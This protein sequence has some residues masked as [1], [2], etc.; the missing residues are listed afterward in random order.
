MSTNGEKNKKEISLNQPN[1]TALINTYIAKKLDELSEAGTFI[2]QQTL[3][4]LELLALTDT[5]FDQKLVSSAVATHISIAEEISQ[6]LQSHEVE[7]RQLEPTELEQ[8]A[9]FVGQ[10]FKPELRSL[11]VRDRDQERYHVPL[12]ESR[13]LTINMHVWRPSEWTSDHDHGSAGGGIAI[14]QG[15]LVEEI[16]HQQSWTTVPR[17]EGQSYSFGQCIHRMGRPNE[18]G[19]EPLSIHAYSGPEGGLTRITSFRR[20]EDGSLS[21]IRIWTKG[22]PSG[23]DGCPC[24]LASL[25]HQEENCDE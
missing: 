11:S 6:W 7:D 15:D 16:Y 12:F 23:V 24:M 22:E 5:D 18:E 2:T 14:V 8:V 9:I 1:N 20:E 25:C 17:T 19:S 10:A 4:N 13:F 21:P 3:G